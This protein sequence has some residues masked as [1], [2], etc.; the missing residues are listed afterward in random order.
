MAYVTI[1]S[2]LCWIAILVLVATYAAKEKTMAFAISICLRT[3]I[4][5]WNV[6]HGGCI[7]VKL[8]HSMTSFRLRGRRVLC[9][10]LDI[11]SQVDQHPDT[12]RRY[13]W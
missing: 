11:A 9:P 10:M 4:L 1:Q 12:T 7:V 8:R 2:F 5:V 6:V 13:D 3:C